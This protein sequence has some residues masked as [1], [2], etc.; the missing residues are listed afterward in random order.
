MTNNT[1]VTAP[2]M[3]DIQT[4]IDNEKNLIVENTACHGLRRTGN[5]PFWQK[6]SLK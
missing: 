3:N 2:I 1:A 5:N 6:V 4:E